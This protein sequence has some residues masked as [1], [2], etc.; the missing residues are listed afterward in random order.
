MSIPSIQGR[1]SWIFTEDNFDVDQIVGV[2]NIKMTDIQELAALAMQSY[3]PDFARLV[4]KGDVVVGG[5]NFGYGH[6]H[7]P[8][9]KALRHLGISAVIAES[10]S[11]GFYRGEISMGFTLVTCPGVR[12]M[13]QRWDQLEVD[14]DALVLHNRTRG[15]SLPI[16]PLSTMDQMMLET[17][18]F[19]PYLKARLRKQQGASGG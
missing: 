6:P 3:D 8:P 16:E 9:L 14:W 11:P 12:Q 10:F 2:K 5:D 13:V 17:G 18:G 19:I 1:A 4:Q 7:Y 15:T